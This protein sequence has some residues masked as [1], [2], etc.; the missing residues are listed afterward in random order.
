MHTP[1]RNIRVIGMLRLSEYPGEDC[2]RPE[3]RRATRR[4][5]LSELFRQNLNPLAILRLHARK[6][7]LI[8]KSDNQLHLDL[9]VGRSKCCLCYHYQKIA[10]RKNQQLVW[11][12]FLLEISN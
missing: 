7:Q 5:R 3:L 11:L 12:M 6:Q 2:A 4:R 10:Y 8:R 9:Q 1:S